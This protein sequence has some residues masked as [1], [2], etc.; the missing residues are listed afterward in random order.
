MP[1][2]QLQLAGLK[3]RAEDRIL[4]LELG[5]QLLPLRFPRSGVLRKFEGRQGTFRPAVTRSV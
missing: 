2:L 5:R 1:D 4:L 3:L